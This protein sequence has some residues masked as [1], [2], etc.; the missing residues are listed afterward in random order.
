MPSRSRPGALAKKSNGCS[1]P[2][3]Q[4]H[5]VVLAHQ[6]LHGQF[7]ADVHAAMERHAFGFHLLHA[8]RDDVLFHLEV[9]DAVHE[10]AAGARVLLVDVHVVTGARELLGGGKACGTRA[11]DG[12]LLAGLLLRRLR[13]DPAF[14]PRAIGDGAFDGLDGDRLVVDVERAG[15]FARRRA[16]A[17]RHL[18]EVVGRMQ[19]GAACFQSP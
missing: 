1:E 5:G 15:G 12:D 8:A 10:Q 16:D 17:A 13:R 6:V 7:L 14:L 9:G 2:I 18:G 3:G 19:V 4:Q 11:D